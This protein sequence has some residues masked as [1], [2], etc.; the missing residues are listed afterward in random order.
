MH[1]KLVLFEVVVAA[2]AGLPAA[3]AAVALLLLLQGVQYT[4][5]VEYRSA[6]SLMLMHDAKYQ[7]QVLLQSSGWVYVE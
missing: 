1:M 5:L 6:A 4:E 3:S 2:V 7:V